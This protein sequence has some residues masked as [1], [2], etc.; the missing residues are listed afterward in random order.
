MARIGS[1]GIAPSPVS[2]EDKLIGTDSVNNDATKNFTIQ[3]I[4]DFVL[5]NID[6]SSSYKVYTASISMSSGTAT[7]FKNTLGTT[8]T[9]TT[10]TGTVSA[11]GAALIG[12]TNVF[13]LASSGAT[14]SKPKIVSIAWSPTPWTILVQQIDFDGAFDSTQSVYVEIRV[15]P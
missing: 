9:W 5:D 7:V 15:Y 14:S 2:S 10:G 4:T 6:P 11:T 13:T 3:E 12:Q 1:Y 8:L